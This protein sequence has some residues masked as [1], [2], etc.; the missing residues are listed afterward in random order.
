MTYRAE[1]SA[2]KEKQLI[3]AN[4]FLSNW[5]FLNMVLFLHAPTC[6]HPIGE[7]QDKGY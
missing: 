7:Y 4:V 2:S 3:T 5:L 1:Q 6:M